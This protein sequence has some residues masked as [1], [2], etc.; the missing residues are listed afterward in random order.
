M[1]DFAEESRLAFIK[2]ASRAPSQGICDTAEAVDTLPVSSPAW[3][4]AGRDRQEFRRAAQLAYLKRTGKWVAN[5]N[6]PWKRE[7]LLKGE[8]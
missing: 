6:R 4:T 5:T 8:K 3:V 7:P 2:N 1:I